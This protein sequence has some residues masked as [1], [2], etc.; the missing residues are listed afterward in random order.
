LGLVDHVF[1]VLPPFFVPF[2]FLVDPAADRFAFARFA[3][4]TLL[5][6]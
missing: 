3:I 4:H 6:R 2:V 5:A 1:V